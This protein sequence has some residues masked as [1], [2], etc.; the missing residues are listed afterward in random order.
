MSLPA[1]EVITLGE[2]M[3][4]LASRDGLP[5][6]QTNDFSIHVAGAESN[7]ALYLA[8]AGVPVSW[9][10]AVGDDPFGE[11]LVSYLSS[12]KVDTSLVKR[13]STRPTGVFFKNHDA[14]KTSVYYYRGGSAASAMSPE[15]LAAMRSLCFSDKAPKLLHLSGV[16]AALSDSCLALSKESMR[17]A[18]E[19]GIDVSFDVNFRPG[20]WQADTA[21]PILQELA[22]L[23]DIVLVGLDEAQALWGCTT[24]EDVQKLLPDV[25]EII[26]KDGG[27]GATWFSVA[28]SKFVPAP[29]VNIV[30]VVGAGDAFA[31][32]FITARLCGETIA[33]QLLTGHHFAARAMSSTAD[34]ISLRD[35]LQPSPGGATNE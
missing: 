10:S 9:L 7:V 33:E 31:A 24:P 32:G 27:I 35:Y 20:L 15:S 19:A 13:D 26:V 4:L 3:I 21:G 23:A 14:H 22:N 18:H 2:S 30:E 28:D 1:L 8:D 12:H 34:F 16:T 5:L 17:I 25:E 29:A 11:R 6:T